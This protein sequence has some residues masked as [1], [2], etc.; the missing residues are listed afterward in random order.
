MPCSICTCTFAC[1]VLMTWPSKGQSRLGRL[2][3]PARSEADKAVAPVQNA[4][5]TAETGGQ[6]GDSDQDLARRL[7]CFLVI[8]GQGSLCHRFDGQRH[9]R[10]SPQSTYSPVQRTRLAEN[11][12]L[13]ALKSTYPPFQAVDPLVREFRVFGLKFD[14]FAIL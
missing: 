8:I 9:G 1:T 5:E 14:I 7:T 6:P 11:S 3:G 2:F 12:V 10:L 13:S 4:M